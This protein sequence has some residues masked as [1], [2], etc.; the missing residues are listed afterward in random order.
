MTEATG[1][2]LFDKIKARTKSNEGQTAYLPFEL[3]EGTVSDLAFNPYQESLG[4]VK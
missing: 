3:H 1:A 4:K 2:V